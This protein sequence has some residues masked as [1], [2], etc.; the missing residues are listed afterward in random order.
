MAAPHVAGVAALMK[1]VYRQLTPDQYDQ[2]LS[3]GLMTEDLGKVGRD[4]LYGNGLIDA[5]KAISIASSAAGNSLPPVD[6]R[7]TA[8]QSILN[9][10]SNRDEL[11]FTINNG[12]GGSLMINSI[13]DNSGGWLEVA[14]LSID[15]FGLGAYSVSINRLLL[16]N[17]IVAHSANITVVSSAGSLT[18]P[19]LVLN[20]SQNYPSDAGVHYI[21]L[22]DVESG[23]ILKQVQSIANN[24]EY[25]YTLDNIPVGNYILVAGSDPNNSNSICDAA[26]A[27]GQYYNVGVGELITIDESSPEFLNLNFETNFQPLSIIKTQIPIVLQ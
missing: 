8:S 26:E 15:S 10:S 1:S 9:F 14:P 18:I 13:Q 3:S 23:Q 19:V 22:V 12:G 11:Q 21:Q 20:G 16:D 25:T 5:Y 6:P 7:V 27:C 2:W 17:I 24:G 4:D